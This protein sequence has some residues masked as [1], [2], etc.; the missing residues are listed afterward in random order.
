MSH[1]HSSNRYGSLN[2]KKLLVAGI[3][4]GFVVLVLL[5]IAVVIVIA[6]V[7]ALFG[8]AGGN[9]G[10]SIESIF[11]GIWK[12]VQ[13]FISALWKQVIANPLQFLTGGNG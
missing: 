10:L 11:S 2:K 6:V 8:K 3:I 12:Y 1:E 9:I 4:I 7:S 5:V 13:E